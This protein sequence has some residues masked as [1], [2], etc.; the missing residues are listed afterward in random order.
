MFNWG[1]GTLRASTGP[2]HGAAND[3]R[4]LLKFP[5]DLWYPYDRDRTRPPWDIHYYTEE[6]AREMYFSRL[7]KISKDINRSRARFAYDE[8]IAIYDL[9]SGPENPFQI[10]YRQNLISILEIGPLGFAYAL[11]WILAI[12]KAATLEMDKDMIQCLI[13]DIRDDSRA[14]PTNMCSPEL[15]KAA[16]EFEEDVRDFL[17]RFHTELPELRESW[18]MALCR[19]LSANIYRYAQ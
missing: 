9:T 14:T 19:F 18:A 6:Q 16:L 7:T 2:D 8:N 12:G 17:R 4:Q 13:E 15:I 11:L 10:A 1:S 3:A 5:E